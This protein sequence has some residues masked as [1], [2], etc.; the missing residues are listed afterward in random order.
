M[1]CLLWHLEARRDG[2][3]RVLRKFGGANLSDDLSRG[4]GDFARKFRRQEN[5]R[6]GNPK[7]NRPF[8][9]VVGDADEIRISLLR[10]IRVKT[11]AKYRVHFSDARRIRRRSAAR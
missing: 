9:A 4:S 3:T 6:L 8:F 7:I 1:R 2:A 10:K 11:S 5:G